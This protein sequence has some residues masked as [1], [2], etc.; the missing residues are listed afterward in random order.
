MLYGVALNH[1]YTVVPPQSSA[2][3]FVGQKIIALGNFA[4][5]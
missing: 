5:S 1:L 2:L 3:E 4:L